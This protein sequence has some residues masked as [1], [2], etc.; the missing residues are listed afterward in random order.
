MAAHR[1]TVMIDELGWSVWTAMGFNVSG[2]GD[3]DVVQRTDLVATP[4]RVSKRSWCDDNVELVI[5]EV[6]WV[7]SYVLLKS[8]FRKPAPEFEQKLRHEWAAESR[9]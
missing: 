5:E 2:T 4:W 1:Q 6:G 9:R 3:C 8:N 7:F